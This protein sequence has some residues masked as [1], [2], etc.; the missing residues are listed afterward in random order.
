MACDVKI[1][2]QSRTALLIGTGH[3]TGYE[4]AEGCTEMVEDAL[5]N[6]GFNEVW[7]LSAARAVDIQ[8]DGLDEL[9]S[10]MHVYADRVGHNRVAFV[11]T[12]ET[13]RILLRLFE[14]LT[15]DLDRSYHTAPSRDEAALWLGLDPRA[16]AEA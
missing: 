7:D 16:L 1:L 6:D 9:V 8:P 4:L 15:R 13:V 5:W 2:S 3:V 14:Q 12:K 10:C 11:T